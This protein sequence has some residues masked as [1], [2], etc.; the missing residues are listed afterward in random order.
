MSL[1]T[2]ASLRFRP[3]GIDTSAEYVV[4]MHAGCHICRAE[5]FAAQTRV[6]VSANERTVIATLN[7][8]R[9]DLLGID[10]ASLSVSA[11]C[12]LGVRAGVMLQFSHVPVLASASHV[13]AK[14]FG[15][16]L[17]RAAMQAIVDDAVSG[18]L[19][20]LHLAAFVTACA[21]ERLTFDETVELTEAMV[22]AGM[23]LDW[24]RHPVVDKHCVGGLPGNRTTP[25]VVAIVTACGLVMPKTSSRAITSPA[26]TADMMEVL[27]P[28][29][30]DADAIRR[31]VDQTGGCIVWGG[32]MQLS[33]ADDVLI[34]IERPLD[35]DSDGQ[36]VASIL[37]KKLSAG[38]E[39]VLIDLPVGPTAKVR[40]AAAAERLTN[41]LIAVGTRLGLRVK[42]RQS[43]G[44]QPV[45]RGIGPSLE[46]R[47]VLQVLN[48]DPQAPQ[49]LV[50]RALALA[51]DVLELG[52]AVALG[53]GLV[54]ARDTL[55][56]GLAWK[57]FQAICA[58]QGGLRAVPQAPLC[59]LVDAPRAGV[60]GA[61][62]NRV[63]ARIAKLA[64]APQ[65]KAAG[66]DLLVKL[67]EPVERQ[68]PLYAIHAEAPGE[69]HYAL[70]YALAHPE[71]IQLEN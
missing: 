42:V 23:R 50:E 58:A 11:Q 13:R 30:L 70:S 25:I 40:D 27:A 71:V 26:G 61:I 12:A 48:N 31:V 6:A 19:S 56:S 45:G 9:G 18:R 7:I 10:E 21:G 14:V 38:S 67:A 20:D 51:G 66:V 44:R 64:G 3:L 35:L 59:H 8:V 60:V 29:D 46:A 55:E 17:D 49:D 54:L 62:D 24:Q 65:S 57:Q 47:D 39:R 2:P 28:V 15:Q 5:G 1:S 33:P 32:G 16:T 69:L 4:Y 63:L 37:S 41:R 52:D 34:R 22:A 36:L 43:D 53:G 68:Q